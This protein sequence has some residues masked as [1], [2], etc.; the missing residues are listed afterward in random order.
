MTRGYRKRF[1]LG[2]YI[3][4]G[5]LAAAAAIIFLGGSQQA[6][7]VFTDPALLWRRIVWPLLR[8][9]FFIS[10][11]LFAGQV[12]EGLGW[13]DRLGVLAR[14]FMRRAHLPA[15]MGAA[16]TTAFVS[17]TASLS[18]LMAFHREGGL[19]RREL[20]LSVL[21]NTFPSFFLHLPT[22]FFVLLPLVG[23]AGLFYLLLTFSAAVVRLVAALAASRI[24]LPPPAEGYAAAGD[25]TAATWRGV[26][27]ETAGK[28]RVRIARIL[29]IVLP[30]YIVVVIA[31]DAG[32]FA[33]LRG[34]LAE[35][36]TTFPIPIEA[37]SVVLFSLV[38]EFTSGYAAAGAMLESG[39]L[40]VSQ[41]VLALLLG[42]IL[43]APIRALRH[44]LPYYMGIFTPKLGL[45]LMAATQLF[46]LFSLALVAGLFL[47]GLAFLT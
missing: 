10:V 33:W 47:A 16:F 36:V 31:S 2:L 30:V 24:L 22:T 40:T 29:V 5:L 11:G 3:L 8:L 41:T 13:T 42:N 43:A 38:A 1:P 15:P 35:S 18:M 14:P 46:R 19:S 4:L 25:S 9:T 17:G 39:A 45:G 12:I 32:L 23:R 6:A 44:Q 20:I 34:L 26:L 28:F 7:G 27:K 37:F 21:L